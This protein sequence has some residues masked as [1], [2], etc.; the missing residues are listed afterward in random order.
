MSS[1]RPISIVAQSS[2]DERI[3]KDEYCSREFAELER[4]YVWP[5][6]WQVACRQEELPNVGSYVTYD[7]LDDSIIVVRTS[8]T[9][10]KAYN[11]ACLHR[12]RRL[13]T[14]CGTAAAFF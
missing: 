14:D 3:P 4:K 2:T 7:I 9:E 5:R 13:T 10:I 1:R 8:S 11:N 6:V 12:G